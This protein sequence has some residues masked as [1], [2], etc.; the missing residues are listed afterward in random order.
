LTAL[1]ALGLSTQVPMNAVYLTDGTPRILNVG[2]RKIVFKK[3][4]PRMFA[5]KS[6][7]F[8]MVVVAMK[9]IGV[10]HITDEMICNIKNILAKEE[11]QQLIKSDFQIAPQWVRKKLVT[12]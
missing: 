10:S 1:N 5:Y 12:I 4:A 2:N 7:L 8:A 3:C 6:E 11:N 9:E